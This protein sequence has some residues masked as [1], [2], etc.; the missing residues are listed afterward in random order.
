[1]SKKILKFSATWCQ[2]CKMLSQTLK[3]QDLGVPV[4]EVD[5]DQEMDLA[6][7]YSVRGVPALV[8]VDEHGTALKSLVGAQSLAAIK[9]WVATA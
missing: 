5:I 7:K 3:G 6:V 2:P 4:Q 1:M 9:N 8:L